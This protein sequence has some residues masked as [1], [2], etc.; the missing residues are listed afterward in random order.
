MLFDAR[1]SGWM[2]V[3]FR[4][5]RHLVGLSGEFSTAVA[6]RKISPFRRAMALRRGPSSGRGLLP[7]MH[8]PCKQVDAQCQ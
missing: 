7:G 6:A 3:S 4:S 8:I 5:L 2:R 1:F